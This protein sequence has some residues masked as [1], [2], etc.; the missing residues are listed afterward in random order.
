LKVIR[1]VEDRGAVEIARR[2]AG[3]CRQVFRYAATMEIVQYDPAANLGDNL[4]KREHKHY[5]SIEA[6][7]LPEFIGVLERNDARLFPQTRLATKL[8]MLTFVPS[9]TALCQR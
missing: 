8:M 3:V 1:K 4:K 5:A 2:L 7:E 6:K 9:R